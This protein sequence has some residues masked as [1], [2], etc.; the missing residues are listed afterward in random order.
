M[1]RL[2]GNVLGMVEKERAWGSSPNLFPMV[3]CGGESL[4]AYGVLNVKRRSYP[5]PTQPDHHSFPMSLLCD[6]A[7]L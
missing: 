7:P 1:S 4:K 3:F 2:R 5:K 6:V